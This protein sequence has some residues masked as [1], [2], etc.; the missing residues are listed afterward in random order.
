M[1]TKPKGWW[2]NHPTIL[3]VTVAGSWDSNGDGIGDFEGIRQHLDDLVAMGV[4][5]L[6]FQQITRFDDDFEWYGLVAQDWFDVDPL[7]G[8]MKDFER[9]MNGCQERDIAVMVMAVPEYLGWQHPD[10]LAASKARRDGLNDPRVDWFS[11]EDDG[12]VET[13]WDRPAPDFAN[14]GYVEAYLEHLRFWM[15]KGVRGWDVDDLYSWKN[16]NVEALREITKCVIERDGF[17]CSEH[18]T[19]EDDTTLRGGFNAG[20]GLHRSGFYREVD[21]IMEGNANYIRQGLA[22][23]KQLIQYGMFPFQQFGDDIYERY[24]SKNKRFKR[25]QFRLQ[26]AFNAALP[27]QVWA[28]ANTIAFPTK[29]LTPLPTPLGVVCWGQLDHSEIARQKNNPESPF[30]F[31]QKMFRLR[32]NEPALGI[33]DLEEL[34]TQLQ[35]WLV[36]S[37]ESSV[38]RL[39]TDTAL[40]KEPNNDIGQHQQSIWQ[41]T[42]AGLRTSEDG[43]QKAVTVFHFSA[44]PCRIEVAVGNQI[45]TLRNFLSGE[46]ISAKEGVVTVELGRYG[47]KLLEVID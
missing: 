24:S 1:M 8:T 23:R 26:V 16:L 19:L 28:L 41:T 34:P 45:K 6:R 11:W 38:Y 22:R 29:A 25:Q 44:D 30:S 35:E 43:S 40:S 12:T 33:G 47:F 27:D 15:D 14:P 17:I 20:T 37:P 32:A 21:A 36:A 5:G 31:F 39:S 9:L 13:T 18:S 10:Y 4:S 46:V 3:N 7:Y 2:T 42:F